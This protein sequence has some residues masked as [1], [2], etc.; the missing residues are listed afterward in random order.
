MYILALVFL[1]IKKPKLIFLSPTINRFIDFDVPLS[2]SLP[3]FVVQL[4]PIYLI[5]CVNWTHSKLILKEIKK[6]IKHNQTGINGLHNLI[7]RPEFRNRRSLK[8]AFDSNPASFEPKNSESRQIKTVVSYSHFLIKFLYIGSVNETK[9]FFQ[10]MDKA[11]TTSLRHKNNWWRLAGSIDFD[12]FP[13]TC[14]F[15]VA[16]YLKL[17]GA[18]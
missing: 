11:K 3:L 2:L 1:Q 12:P 8:D 5:S 6:S 14:F 9:K 16:G 4:E 17:I 7:R 13:P 15:Q 10:F 18:T